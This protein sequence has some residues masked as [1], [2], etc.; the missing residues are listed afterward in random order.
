MNATL[1][2]AFEPA[3][4]GPLQLKNRIIKAATF[5]G[6]TPDGQVTREL[7]DFHKDFCEGG[8]AMT[9]IAYCATEPD[10]RIHENMILM[11]EE[12]RDP[13]TAM[14]QELHATGAKVSGQMGHCGHFSKNKKLQRL[15]R[16][17]GPSRHFNNLGM[18]IG[19]PFAGAMTEADIDYFVNSYYEAA[20]FMKDIGFDAVEIHFGHGYALSQFISPLTNRRR[21]Q[22]GGSIENRMR[23]PLRALQAVRKAVGD[24][25]PIL[26]KMGMFDAVRGGLKEP[27]ALVVAELLDR[28]GIDAIITSGGTSSYNPMPMFRG[29]SIAPGIIKTAPNLFSKL[30]VK[31]MAP[32]MFKDMPYEELYFLDGHKRVRER[33]KN[34]QMVYVGGCHTMESLEKVMAEGV[35]FV[36]LGRILIKDPAFVNNAMAKG[37]KYRSGCTHCNYCVTS[38]DLPGGVHCILNAEDARAS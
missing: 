36:Q 16:P 29:D 1:S 33:V 22:Y 17:L 15:K 7:I 8:V 5:E 10:G 27:E 13:L 26:G 32:A 25:F 38:I 14:L 19:R 34:A 11:T 37:E 31:M 20:L 35:D 2:K 9:T 6:K 12:M 28:E 4:L 23:V 30:L 24:D 21:D 18:M 3:K